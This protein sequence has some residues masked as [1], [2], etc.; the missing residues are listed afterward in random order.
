M[1]IASPRP[2]T[3]AS[4][5]DQVPQWGSGLGGWAHNLLGKLRPGAG[6]RRGLAAGSPAP[7][8]APASLPPGRRQA[9]NPQEATRAGRCPGR[10]AA[11]PWRR[12]RRWRRRPG[13]PLRVPSPPAES[14]RP[15]WPPPP[16]RRTGGAGGGSRAG[17]ARASTAPRGPP[18]ALGTPAP[19]RAWR[20]AL[21]DA[22][23]GD[24]GAR[25]VPPRLHFRGSRAHCTSG[26]LLCLRPGPT[27]RVP[28]ALQV[29]PHFA[30]RSA[31]DAAARSGLPRP[32]LTLGF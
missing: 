15:A 13:L 23:G 16:R 26:R 27:R 11:L 20:A 18:R 28:A 30:R 29:D 2:G 17:P 25:R 6:S 12:P 5:Q 31:G 19:A 32:R 10:A 22:L 14:P 9:R 24:S 3:A 7:R 1:E 4:L 21:G 8:R